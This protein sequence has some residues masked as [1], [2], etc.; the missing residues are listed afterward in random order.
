MTSRSDAPIYVGYLPTPA[1]HRRFV[2]IAAPLLA[3]LAGAAGLAT[4]LAQRDPGAAVWSDG[5]AQSFRGVLVMRPYPMV[6]PAS[7]AP[8]LL[9]EMGKRGAREGAAAFEGRSVEA[10]GWL[11][12]REGRRMLELAPESDAIRV[13][14][15]AIDAPIDEIGSPVAVTLEGEIVDSKCFLGAMKPGDGKGH[16]A[17]AT[18]CVT[19]GVP[20]TLVTFDAAGRAVGF[21]VLADEAGGPANELAAPYLGEPVTVEGVLESRAG[22]RVLRVGA[23]GVRRR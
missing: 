11:L 18:L 23:G 3:A 14:D 16:K 4:A 1:R 17:C 22:L 20:P 9:V 8:L 7:G 5:E 15:E 6:V 13:I 12:A 2:R 21:F 10:T 19:G